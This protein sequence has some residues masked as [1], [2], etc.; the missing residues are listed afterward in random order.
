MS[1]SPPEV[2]KYGRGGLKNLEELSQ[3]HISCALKPTK[4]APVGMVSSLDR[5]RARFSTRHMDHS[6]RLKCDRIFHFHI[7]EHYILSCVFA[8]ID[9]MRYS[10]R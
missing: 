1:C 3:L 2:A 8:N 7:I 4:M 10:P 5:C 6:Q 9:F